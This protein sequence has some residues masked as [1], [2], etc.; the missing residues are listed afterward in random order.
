[1]DVIHLDLDCPYP[2]SVASEC[3]EKVTM[4]GGWCLMSAGTNEAL[5]K[6]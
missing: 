5:G 2:Y 3:K 4:E 6:T 1:M